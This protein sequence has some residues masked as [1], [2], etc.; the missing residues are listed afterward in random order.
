MQLRKFDPLTISREGRAIGSSLTGY[1]KYLYQ[2]YRIYNGT[3]KK[4]ALPLKFQEDGYEGKL[5]LPERR[6]VYGKLICT[7]LRT[8]WKRGALIFGVKGGVYH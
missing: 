7:E 1:K 2:V 6:P 4:N 8:S 5:G 3:S